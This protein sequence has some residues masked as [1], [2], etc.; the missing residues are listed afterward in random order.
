WEARPPEPGRVQPRP[1]HR[2]GRAAGGGRRLR[3]ALG[4]AP[5]RARGPRRGAALLPALWPPGRRRAGRGAVMDARALDVVDEA[6]AT[7]SAIRPNGSH[8][9]DEAAPGLPFAILDWTVETRFLGDP[10]EP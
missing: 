10:P 2:L 1:L 9:P 4:R 8:G 7:A 6:L 3:P 5:G